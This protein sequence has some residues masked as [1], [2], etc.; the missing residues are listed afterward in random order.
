[1]AVYKVLQDIEAEDKLLGPLTL[2]Q[3]IYAAIAIGCAF[4]AFRLL[5]VKWWLSVPF[6]PPAI[7]F[8]I[9]AAPFGRDQPTEIWLVAKVR[10]FLKPRKRIWNQTGI[11][12]LVTITAP[13]R[14]EKRLT[15]DL[16]QDQVKSRLKALAATL[17][18]RGWAI[19][20]VNVN[21]S[22]GQP[23][24]A[25]AGSD[26]LLDPSM[27]PQEVPA[28]GADIVDRDDMLADKNRVSQQLDTMI[29]ASRQEQRQDLINEMSAIRERQA[30]GQP[31]PTAQANW[32]MNDPNQQ[33]T[34]TSTEN[35]AL[36]ARELAARKTSAS[37]TFSGL[38][39]VQPPSSNVAPQAPAPAA[40]A[41]P[42]APVKAQAE[43][44]EVVDPAIVER[45]QYANRDD[46]N[47]LT[48]QH[49]VNKQD[50]QP[51]HSEEFEIPLHDNDKKAA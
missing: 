6:L 44:T 43:M 8:G 5:V 27:L 38:K 47:V 46:L 45:T 20:N 28:L 17:D 16:N 42:Q 10:F 48:I 4:L 19:K 2:R 25:L 36:I 23:A 50:Q 37:N 32:F 31:E 39:V 21:L 35:E 3:F 13:K 7:L 26:R 22:A 30:A 49:I 15:K 34:Q 1:M 24:Y 11:K 33:P 51:A 41:P 14:I 29:A 12:E 9:L 18:S 40:A